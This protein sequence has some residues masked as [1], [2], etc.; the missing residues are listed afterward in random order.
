MPRWTEEAALGELVVLVL[1]IDALRSEQRFSAAHAR[2]L[3]KTLNFLEEVF[4]PASI[5]FGTVQ[6]LPWHETGSMIVRG[7]DP[8][9]GLERRH[10][11]AYLRQLETAKGLLQAAAEELERRS[12]SEVYRGKDT[13][14]ES[15]AIIKVLSLVERKLR[16][17]MRSQ[18]ER[19]VE[20]QDALESLLIAADIEY[21]R[22]ADAIPYSSKTYRPD[23]TLEKLDLAIDVKICGRT[24]R[25]KEIIGEV[26]DDI[27]A[28]KTK[29]GNLLFVIYDVGMIRD[30]DFFGEQFEKSEGVVV[31][32][33]KH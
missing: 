33:I 32:V 2:W 15:S 19:E 18:P 22:E 12:L 3:T 28:Y 27:L 13:P 29:Y 14:T 31:R 30:I 6:S 8:Q 5:Y 1:E 25:E 23:F 7:F 4:G 20:V 21:R 24:D 26:N 10:Q 17:V 16:K 9:A 11:E